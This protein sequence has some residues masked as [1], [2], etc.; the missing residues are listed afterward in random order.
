MKGHHSSLISHDTRVQ[1][2]LTN[3]ALHSGSPQSS[4]I[5]TSQM[6]DEGQNSGSP[7]LWD[8]KFGIFGSLRVTTPTDTLD[9]KYEG[10]GRFAVPGVDRGE[11]VRAIKSPPIDKSIPQIGKKIEAQ[12]DDMDSGR[13][14]LEQVL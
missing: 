8:R 12:S 7:S 2:S 1:S 5:Q 9:T 13:G 4:A 6:A 3:N 10:G 11:E 14:C